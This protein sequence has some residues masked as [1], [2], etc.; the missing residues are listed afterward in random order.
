MI[1][2]EVPFHGLDIVSNGNLITT[3]RFQKCRMKGTATTIENSVPLSEV[4]EAIKS[5]SS[6]ISMINNKCNPDRSMGAFSIREEYKPT[7]E[8]L[9]F[10]NEIGD[11][12]CSASYN[13][14]TKEF[15]GAMD[16]FDLKWGL[17]LEHFDAL[18]RYVHLCEIII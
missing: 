17:F 8:G 2:Q 13:K 15:T 1:F 4:Q 14:E 11:L 7:P 10:E 6:F 18:K 5:M 12:I 16:A 3:Y 9:D